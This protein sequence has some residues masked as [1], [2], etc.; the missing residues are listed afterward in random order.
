[1]TGL[2]RVILI[3]LSYVLVAFAIAIG[4]FFGYRC[5]RKWGWLD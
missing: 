5:A 3:V 2:I 1:M 4:W